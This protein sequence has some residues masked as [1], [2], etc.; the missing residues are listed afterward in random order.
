MCL[1]RE[2]VAGRVFHGYFTERATPPVIIK[3]IQAD[4]RLGL[5]LPPPIENRANA[6]AASDLGKR[7][8]RQRLF[9]MILKKPIS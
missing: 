2:A 4:H 6:N 1:P 5:A 7:K 9:A 8:R 3:L